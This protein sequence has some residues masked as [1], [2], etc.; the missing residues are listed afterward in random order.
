MQVCQSIPISKGVKIEQENKVTLDNYPNCEMGLRG[1]K[2][3]ITI[4]HRNVP[5]MIS[6]FATILAEDGINISDMTNKSKNAY[7]YSI[8]DVDGEITDMTAD[9]VVAQILFLNSQNSDKDISLYINSP[10]GT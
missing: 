10:G 1:D 6:Q 3:R 5:N 8:F 7:A 2:T 9:L 4:A